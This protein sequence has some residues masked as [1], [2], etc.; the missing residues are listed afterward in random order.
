MF[1]LQADSQRKSREIATLRFSM[2]QGSRPGIFLQAL[3]SLRGNFVFTE[4]ID[5]FLV[6]SAPLLPPS[7]SETLDPRGVRVKFRK[8]G[9]FRRM[10]SSHRYWFCAVHHSKPAPWRSVLS[11]PRSRKIVQ[12]WFHVW[13]I[14]LFQAEVSL[15]LGFTDPR[16]GKRIIG[17]A[18]NLN[19]SCRF[20][21]TGVD[22]KSAFQVICVDTVRMCAAV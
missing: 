20:L 3:W 2:Q 15:E 13:G 21:K 1:S 11:F 16:T 14:F 8:R 6:F 10:R 7:Y 12:G 18:K 9:R 4:G 17:A 19:S 22:L 5:R